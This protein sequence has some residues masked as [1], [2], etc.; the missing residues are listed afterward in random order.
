MPNTAA[1]LTCRHAALR[2][3][4]EPARDKTL[5][6]MAALGFVNCGLSAFRASFLA[7]G[8]TCERWAA[9]DAKTTAARLAW[10]ESKGKA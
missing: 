7:F 1:C 8:A 3:P 4:G 2:D 5:R 9:G 6:A 10:A